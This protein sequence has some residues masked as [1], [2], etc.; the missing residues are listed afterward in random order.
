M[1]QSVQNQKIRGPMLGHG[2]E[3]MPVSPSDA[4]VDRTFPFC[5]TK[6]G[7]SFLFRNQNHQNTHQVF[8]H[9]THPHSAE[10]N[11]LP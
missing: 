3:S 5:M 4:E 10:S 6:H 1:F 9:F 8:H 2:S 11:L 7:I